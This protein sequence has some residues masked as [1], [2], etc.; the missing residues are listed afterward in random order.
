MKSVLAD[1]M[2]LYRLGIMT[3]KGIGC[4]A[5]PEKAL[6][7]LRKSAEMNNKYAL[8]EYGKQLVDGVFCPKM[9]RK[10]LQC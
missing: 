3:L 8:C 4:E 9:L 2:L 7:Y 10:V 5:A 1:N 6:D